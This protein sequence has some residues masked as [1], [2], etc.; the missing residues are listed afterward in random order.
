MYTNTLTDEQKAIVYQTAGNAVYKMYEKY[1]NHKQAEIICKYISQSYCDDLGFME[2]FSVID[3]FIQQIIIPLFDAQNHNGSGYDPVLPEPYPNP[4]S[5]NQ[6]CPTN[7]A[8]EI[9]HISCG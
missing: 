2:Y 8:Q 5:T 7:I 9:A 6:N 4:Y 1:I 3:E